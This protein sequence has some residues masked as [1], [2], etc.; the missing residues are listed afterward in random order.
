MK[1]VRIAMY[2]RLSKEDDKIKTESNSISMQRLLIEDYV[3]K[4]FTDYEL[5]EYVDDGF[6]G[7]NLNRPGMFRLLGE[8]GEGKIDCIIV[9]DFS[10]FARD[11]IELGDYLEQIFP[12]LGIRFI[13]INDQYDS[14]A[15]RGS[16]ADI[17]MHFKNLLYDLYS[18]D[19][20]QKVR[21][22]LA[23][24]KAK[25]QYVSAHTP[26]GYQ[27][28]PED[29]HMLIIKED[30]ARIVAKIFDL[31]FQGK[32]KN[33]IA[34]KLNEEGVKTP[35]EFKIEMGETTRA[36]KGDGF[37]WSSSTIASILKNEIYVGD[38]VY[39]KTEKKQIGGKNVLKP[40][41]EW[42]I[43]RNHHEAIVSRERFGA[44]QKKHGKTVIRR[45]VPPKSVLQ[46]LAV[47]A[48]CKKSLLYKGEYNPYFT[49]PTRYCVKESECLKKINVMYLEQAVLF[50]LGQHL[51]EQGLISGFATQQKQDKADELRRIKKVIDT[52]KRQYK[53]MEKSN[54]NNYQSYLSGTSLEFISLA[55][56]LAEKSEEIRKLEEKASML[57][58]TVRTLEKGSNAHGGIHV[59]LK[60]ELLDRYIEN[61]M[62]KDEDYFEIRWKEQGKNL[63]SLDIEM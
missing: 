52:Q 25:G 55:K 31:A 42:K 21:T 43:Y 4:N 37:Q 34:Q 30:E 33:Q 45:D 57:E 10:R 24:R 56:E 49:C 35:I 2:L 29:R 47:C 23:A 15:Y 18:K 22:A 3:Q 61:I 58:E 36:P 44:I 48:K 8:A 6:S 17:D 50:E 41:S 13:S 11:Y 26:F 5:Q 7:T 32:T 14:S 53:I 40:R 20:S 38:I 16:I 12:F 60:R 27:K 54:Y 19:L 28:D 59:E 39:G 9:K 62:V 46:G 51:T 63:H 1:R